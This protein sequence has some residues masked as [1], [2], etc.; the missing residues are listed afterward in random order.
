ME[1]SA[2]VF[3]ALLQEVFR[4]RQSMSPADRDQLV[5]DVGTVLGQATI[6]ALH[7]AFDVFNPRF[8]MSG[9]VQPTFLGM[10]FGSSVLNADI[11]IDKHGVFVGFDS[12]LH[13]LTGKLLANSILPA[14]IGEFLFN[15]ASLGFSDRLRFDLKLPLD[16]V[17]T[18]LFAD[19][20]DA[21]QRHKLPE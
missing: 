2:K 17:F 7:A 14:G 20:Q 3:A 10:P 19:S 5:S 8:V 1:D 6:E 12:S 18:T 21:N 4:A 13:D 11:S 9:I 15:V 16:N